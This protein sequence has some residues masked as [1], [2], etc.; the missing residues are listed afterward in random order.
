MVK[1]LLV[2]VEEDK[3]EHKRQQLR[4]LAEINGTLRDSSWTPMGRTW[5][6][7][8]IYCKHCGEISHTTSDCPLKGK[9]IDKEVIDADYDSFMSEIGDIG[10]ITKS[11]AEKSYDDFMATLAPKQGAPFPGGPSWPGMPPGM[12]PPGYGQAFPPQGFPAGVPQGY[13]NNPN[14]PP[15]P[16]GGQGW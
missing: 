7:P 6:S 2:P 15:G 16:P 14:L 10:D 1:K 8:D 11:E 12:P 13:W 9:I 3:N 4:K 5:T